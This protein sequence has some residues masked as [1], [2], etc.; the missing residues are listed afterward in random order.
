MGIQNF[1]REALMQPADLIPY[2]VGQELAELYPDKRILEGRNWY[3]D[4]DAFICA[5]KCSVIAATSVFAHVKTYWEGVGKKQKQHIENGWLNVL[6]NGHLFDVILITWTENAYRRRHY[7]VIADDQQLTESFVAAVCEWSC[8]VQGEIVVYHDGY[9]EKDKALF[10]SIKSATFENLILRDSLKAEVQK[11][12]EQ[13][14]NSRN[15]YERYRIPWKRGA[16]F[17][18]PPGNGK[19]HTIKALINKLGKACI[20]VRGFKADCGTDQENMAEGFKRARMTTPCIVALA[21]LDAMIPDENRAF[22]LNEL[23]GF[24]VNTGVMVIATTNHPEKLDTAILDRPS[25]F[26]RK[27]YFNLPNH[28]ERFAYLLNWNNELQ[29]ELRISEA[30]ATE[31]AA[32]TEGFSFAYLKELVLSTMVQ[33]MSEDRKTPM[34]T[35]LAKQ[36]VTL[37]SQMTGPNSTVV[38]AATRRWKFFRGLRKVSSR[39]EEK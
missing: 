35:V 13:F 2:H 24:E 12:F 34:G 33:W 14:L 32:A 29:D 25:R 30:V 1:I 20:Y 31:I 23:D 18:G 22:F 3:F 10:D 38:T 37:R 11:D 16:L 39:F 15:L 21:D 17:I 27:Y 4:L 5:E 8:E 26:D 19:T 36:L 9:F 7:W 28:D 6:W